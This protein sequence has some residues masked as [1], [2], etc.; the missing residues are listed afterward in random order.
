MFLV[1]V[2][3]EERAF[4]QAL[5]AERMAANQVDADISDGARLGLVPNSSHQTR[6]MI[7]V[8]CHPDLTTFGV[9]GSLRTCV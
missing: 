9:T 6:S 7:V 3:R 1:L 8:T 4:A 5:A 2:N